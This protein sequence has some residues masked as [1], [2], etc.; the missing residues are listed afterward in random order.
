MD[1]N[2]EPPSEDYENKGDNV[3]FNIVWMFFELITIFKDFYDMTVKSTF[4]TLTNGYF[5]TR[6]TAIYK[7]I[8]DEHTYSSLI[9][10]EQDQYFHVP[11]KFM[12]YADVPE[13]GGQNNKYIIRNDGEEISHSLINENH[14]VSK[15]SILV[16]RALIPN[17]NEK[18]DINLKLPDNYMI[19]GN[20]FTNYFIAWYL[21]KHYSLSYDYTELLHTKLEYMNSTYKVETVSAPYEIKINEKDVEIY[22][23]DTESEVSTDVYSDSYEDSENGNVTSD[24]ESDESDDKEEVV[25]TKESSSSPT[26]TFE[27]KIETNEELDKLDSKEASSTKVY[28]TSTRKEDNGEKEMDKPEGKVSFDVSVDKIDKKPKRGRKKNPIGQETCTCG[29]CGVEYHITELNEYLLC[30]HCT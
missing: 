3:F 4:N 7:G 15:A 13:N 27:K 11:Y 1:Y 30:G 28:R 8:G 29:I 14:N 25:I 6:V 10:F 16:L 23:V 21:L 5:S 19:V 17:S 22:E 2:M 26:F 12:I 20:V 18:Y 9:D 24:H